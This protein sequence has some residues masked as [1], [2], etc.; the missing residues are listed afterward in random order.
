MSLNIPKKIYWA[1]ETI[2]E[3]CSKH[4]ECDDC[5]INNFCLVEFPS[6]WNLK[7]LKNKEQK[8]T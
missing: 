1:L 5:P 7:L 2:Q 8:D 3:Y 6:E 4:P